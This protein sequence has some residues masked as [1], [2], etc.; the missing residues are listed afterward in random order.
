MDSEGITLPS[1]LGVR[2]SSFDAVC[3]A[4]ENPPLTSAGYLKHTESEKV[5]ICAEDA[6]V[7]FQPW[8]FQAG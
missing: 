6:T 7:G 1:L 2:T 3:A 5:E 8:I 4:F